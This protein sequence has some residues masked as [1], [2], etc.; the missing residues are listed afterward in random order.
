MFTVHIHLYCILASLL[1]TCS[2]TVYLHVYCTHTSLLY[3]YM[4]TVHI[5][6]YC[7]L[8]SLLHTCFFT[9]HALHYYIL[10]SFLCSYLYMCIVTPDI[11]S[12]YIRA[13]YTY[14]L[15][16]PSH[17]FQ[18]A[19]TPAEKSITKAKTQR[20]QYDGNRNVTVDFVAIAS[21]PWRTRHTRGQGR[22]AKR[23]DVRHWQG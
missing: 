5:H 16:T 13:C 3:T 11:L 6:L 15:R 12:F 1:F 20:N 2:F 23:L 19:R 21:P 8:T 14:S 22:S 7:I 17:H 10:S 9:T 4:F 18:H